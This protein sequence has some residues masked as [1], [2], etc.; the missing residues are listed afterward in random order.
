MTHK[1]NVSSFS[2]IMSHSWTWSSPIKPTPLQP[3]FSFPLP[4]LCFNPP[5]FFNSLPLSPPSLLWPSHLPT[6]SWWREMGSWL[7]TMFFLML[8][9]MCATTLSLRALMA[10][11]QRPRTARRKDEDHSK[12]K[13]GRGGGG[14]KER[15]GR[16][17]SREGKKRKRK[18]DRR[19]LWGRHGFASFKG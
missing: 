6:K 7:K 4:P 8:T 9:P 1:C 3:P 5:P 10:E 19:Q 12:V 17:R 14:G 16:K 2:F 18:G 13:E 15:K 11:R